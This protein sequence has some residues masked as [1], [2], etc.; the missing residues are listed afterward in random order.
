MTPQATILIGVCLYV[1]L[2]LAVG[3]WA[4]SRSHTLTD[5][6]VAGR[7]MPLWL[8]GISI[9]ASWFGGKISV[10]PVQVFEKREAREG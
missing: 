5:F 10:Q 9:F 4:S 6:V 3:V 8:C 7:D 2:M 1:V